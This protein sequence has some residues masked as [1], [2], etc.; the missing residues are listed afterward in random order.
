MSACSIAAS[1]Q[2][3]DYQIRFPNAEAK[4]KQLIGLFAMVLVLSGCASRE[5]YETELQGY[6][7][8]PISV[9]IDSWGYPSG[10]FESPNG[11][12][13]YIW[14]KQSQYISP[15]TVQTSVFGGHGRGIST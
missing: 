10:S 2:T 3:V 6:V 8:K 14:D 12:L 13:V 5:R 7:G 9:V 4:M 1:L 15:P 11:N